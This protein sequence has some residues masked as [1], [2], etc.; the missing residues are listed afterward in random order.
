MATPLLQRLV[1]EWIE[2]AAAQ[3]LRE[4]SIWLS[5]HTAQCECAICLKDGRKQMLMET[6]ASIDAIKAALSKYPELRGRIFFTMLF[7]DV[8]KDS[9]ECLAILPRE[10]KAERVYGRNKA[11]DKFA[12]DGNWLAQYSGPPLGPGYFTVRYM[13]DEVKKSVQEYFDAKYSALYC[14]GRTPGSDTSNQWERGFCNYQYSAVA[15]WSWN[16]KGRDVR[17]F[18]EAWATLNNITPPEQFAAWIEVVQPVESFARYWEKR[19][20]SDW[21]TVADTSDQGQSNR[22][23]TT[24]LPEPEKSGPCLPSASKR[25]PWRRKSPTSPSCWRAVILKHICKPWSKSAVYVV[26]VLI[27]T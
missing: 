17:Q 20:T 19:P 8:D 3:G 21:L 16:A 7:G 14:R 25:C 15:E 4:F 9:S 18:A 12:A 13:A 10:I 1:T 6:Q 27:K 24:K 23:W 11:F 26:T 5:E 22:V 2:S